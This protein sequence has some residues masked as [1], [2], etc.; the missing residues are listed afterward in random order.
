MRHFDNP[1]YS[2]CSSHLALHHNVKARLPSAKWRDDML[3]ITRPHTAKKIASVGAVLLA[4]STGVAVAQSY[5]REV[6][7][8]CA[9]ITATMREL[10]CITCDGFRD[11][12]RAACE[13]N[14]GR[15]PGART[16]FGTEP[17]DRGP[18]AEDRRAQ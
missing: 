1:D 11:R 12:M 15:I 6:V 16:V 8:H 14:G 5:P 17:F 9:R 7:A 10:G 13:A 18:T 3:A 4:L 2:V